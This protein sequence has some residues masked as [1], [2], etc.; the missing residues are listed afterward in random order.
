MGGVSRLTYFPAIPSFI[1]ED[2]SFFFG[3]MITFLKN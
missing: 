3:S 1:P 2:V